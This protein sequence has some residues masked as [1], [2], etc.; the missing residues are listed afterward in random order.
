M[1][2]GM[3]RRYWVVP[4]LVQRNAFPW[5]HTDPDGFVSAVCVL[6]SGRLTGLAGCPRLI[7]I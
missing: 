5:S 6:Q 4:P 1:G 3:R 2:V 7:G